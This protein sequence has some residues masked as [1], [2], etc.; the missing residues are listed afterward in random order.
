MHYF[1]YRD[2]ELF[3]E[4]VPVRRIAKEI[5]TPTYIYSL[6]TLRRHYRVFD[7]AFA[8]IPHI[9]CF[10]VKAN[11]NLAVLRAFVKE[12]GGCDIVSRGELYRALK[13][14]ADPKKL[15]SPALARKK[16]RSSMRSAP[17]FSCSM[18]NPIRSSTCLTKSPVVRAKRRR[19]ACGSTLMSI[20]RLI[21]ISPQG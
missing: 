10:S 12:G 13:A 5:G 3:A 21:P 8:R 1:D 18:W 17:G 15:S 16:R 11:S 6:A 7:Q 4:G 9:V 14:G 19:S 20:Q 2:R